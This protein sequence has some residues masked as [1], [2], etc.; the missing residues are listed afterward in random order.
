MITNAA[1]RGSGRCSPELPSQGLRRAEA[2]E[3]DAVLEER[4]GAG[5]RGQRPFICPLHLVHHGSG[6]GA[7]LPGEEPSKR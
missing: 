7:S 5:H 4:R 2:E 3:F 1:G 6:G